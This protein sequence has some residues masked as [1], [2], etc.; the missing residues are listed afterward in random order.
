MANE[1]IAAGTAP[2]LALAVKNDPE[3][4]A[5]VIYDLAMHGDAPA[6]EVFRRVGN[7]LGIVIA[8]M[9]NIFNF[10]M[11]VIGG[12]VASAWE[13][14]A[15]AMMETVQRNSFVYRATN[16]TATPATAQAS[17]SQAEP[18]RTTVV[19]RALLGSDAGLIGASR[20]PMVA[21]EPDAATPEFRTA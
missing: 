17:D 13:A 8:D 3:F 9:V 5:K 18:S 16:P 19:T 4:T 21:K 2:Q 7:A 20:L 10:P 14:F 1:A 6:R 15:P 12:G 11:Y